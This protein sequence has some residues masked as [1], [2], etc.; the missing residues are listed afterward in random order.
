MK[1]LVPALLLAILFANSS[2][3]AED[4]L[5]VQFTISEQ[6]HDSA[7]RTSLNSSVLMKLNEEISFEIGGQYVL[8]IESRRH[9]DE[10][11]SLL[12]SL[13]DLID[14]K[15][16]YVGASATR[17]KVGENAELSLQN[18]DTSYIIKLD[19]SYGKLPDSAN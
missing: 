12:V 2:E 10:M 17:L 19:T 8:K 15:P 14:G 3:A 18:Y 4:G 11:I 16:Y 6:A 7:A 9:S 13:K 5:M 1:I